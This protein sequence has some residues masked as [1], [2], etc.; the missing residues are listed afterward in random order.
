MTPLARICAVT[1]V[2]LL[3]PA[4]CFGARPRI[5]YS[6]LESGP[7]SGGEN[8]AGAIVT[9][10]GRW[11][12]AVQ[13][14][15]YVTVGGGRAVSYRLW[16]DTRIAFQPGPAAQTGS[17]VVH[18]AAGNSNQVPFAVR[19][20]RIFFV[21][22][23]GSD[24]G[25]GSFS[26]PWRSLLKAR[27]TMAAG[28]ITYAMNGVSQVTDD[29]EGWDSTFTLRA[30]WCGG[31]SPRALIAYPGAAVTIGHLTKPGQGIRGVDSSAGGGACAGSWVFAGLTLRGR[32]A[33]NLWGPSSNWRFVANDLSC[34]AGDGASGCFAAA[35][36]SGIRLLGNRVH[37]A[38]RAGAS[39]LYHGVYF[40][41]DSNNFEMGWNVVS[42]VQGCRGVQA[43]SHPLGAFA[44]E[45]GRNLY[46]I[47]IHDNII[48]DT[49][50][51]GIVL[52]TVDPS[53]GKVE[54][55]NN[56]IYD[57]GLG[58]TPELTGNWSCVNVV[59]GTNFGAAGGGVVDLYNNTMYNCGTNPRAPY[60]DA[61]NAIEYGGHNPD[62]TVRLR[63]NIVY[64]PRGVPYIVNF[65]RPGNV[66]GSNNLFFG[67][68]TPPSN[69]NLAQSIAS[70]PLFAGLADKD[71]HIGAGSPARRAGVETG[72]TID[73][74]GNPR[75]GPAGYDIGAYQYAGADAGRASDF[76]HALRGIRFVFGGFSL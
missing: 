67:N 21:S 62:L 60:R 10:Y 17:I 55:Y 44:P 48:H 50:C 22:T 69:A 47:S 39:A 45:S 66:G 72:A 3:L 4:W 28:D 31:G 52:H 24:S 54:V 61:A 14:E 13:G 46:G 76:A 33:V 53:R 2:V 34:P 37:D 43:Y 49:Q 70:D 8:N 64:Q 27:N 65:G 58:N 38:G 29:G 51:D 1:G 25:S 42:R 40:G 63:N 7:K 56:V 74:D 71:F 9:V 6:D 32:T 12:G 30:G 35:L 20:G 23:T 19:A 5:L 59:G 41:T 68:G 16:T 15:S 36:A 18:T 57:A 75:G 11:F 73:I 26:S